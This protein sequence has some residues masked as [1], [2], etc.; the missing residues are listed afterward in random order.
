MKKVGGRLRLDLAQYR[1]LEAFAKFGSDLDKS[2]QQRLTRGARMVEVLKQKQYS[3]MSVE[4]Q[5]AFIFAGTNGY[6]DDVPLTK[7][8]EFE[9][10]YTSFMQANHQ[11]LLD[12][13]RTSGEISDKLSDALHAAV[14]SFKQGFSTEDQTDKS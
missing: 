2:T 13:I 11:D 9:E 3:P 6:L 14:K 10:N 12:D 8:A 1:E 7:V 4:N 5:V